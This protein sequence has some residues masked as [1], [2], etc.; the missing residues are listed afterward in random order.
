MPT[1]SPLR[2]LDRRRQ[3]N[4]EGNKGTEEIKLIT[5]VVQR[6]EVHVESRLI[7]SVSL[8]R[9]ALL[10][11]WIPACTGMTACSEGPET[12]LPNIAPSA[13]IGRAWPS[14]RQ[15]AFALR[16]GG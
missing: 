7:A 2:R 12:L 11:P 5:K 8:I 16:P 14:A 1:P 4:K 10:R 13:L 3:G 9:H 15:S 6:Y